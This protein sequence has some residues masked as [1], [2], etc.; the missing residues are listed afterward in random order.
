[1]PC[2]HTEARPP[3]L[4]EIVSHPG[5][6]FEC[7]HDHGRSAALREIDSRLC[8]YFSPMSASVLF[9]DGAIIIGTQAPER[10][11]DLSTFE[12]NVPGVRSI[13]VRY[14]HHALRHAPVDKGEPVK[15][16]PTAKEAHE[17]NRSRRVRLGN[18]NWES[19]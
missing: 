1:M 8:E 18:G 14:Q 19:D 2:T 17:R 4:Q 12:S 3:T 7:H 10:K 13:S 11:L 6:N 16:D 9:L 15:V 5:L